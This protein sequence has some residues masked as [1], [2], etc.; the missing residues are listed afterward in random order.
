MKRGRRFEDSAH[1]SAHTFE[2]ISFHFHVRVY[3]IF[4]VCRSINYFSTP[5]RFVIQIC[6]NLDRLRT[7]E[8]KVDNMLSVIRFN[9]EN[10]WRVISGAGNLDDCPGLTFIINSRRRRVGRSLTKASAK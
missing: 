2:L 7:I 8:R 6:F 9:D 10:R 3:A 5:N 4:P 1:S